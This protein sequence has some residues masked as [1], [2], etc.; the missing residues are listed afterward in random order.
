MCSYEWFRLRS[1]TRHEFFRMARLNDTFIRSLLRSKTATAVADGQGLTFTIS[2]KGTAAWVVR[3][4]YAGR[5]REITLGRYP[6]LGLKEARLAAARVRLDV[7]GGMDPA[8]EKKAQGV[9]KR[10]DLTVEELFEEYIRERGPELSPVT[11]RNLRAIFAKDVIP[12]IGSRLARDVTPAEIVNLIRSVKARSYSVARCVWEGL[13]T[14]L[15][16]AVASSVIETNP[17][18]NL[19]PSVVLGKRPQRKKRLQLTPGELMVLCAKLGE[20]GPVNRLAVLVL[21]ATCVRKSE[22]L[23]AK[24]DEFDLQQGIW[25]VPAERIGNKARRAYVI[26]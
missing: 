14:V 26:P 3:Y 24:W 15:A 10:D 13:S 22:L 2:A 12:K 7:A 9:K 11:V 19:K 5:P 25:T 8:F 6:E 1:Y 23:E 20:L 17:Y 18:I 16:Y 21:L 4:R